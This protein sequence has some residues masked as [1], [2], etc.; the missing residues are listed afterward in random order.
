[1]SFIALFVFVLLSGQTSRLPDA[2][3]LLAQMDAAMDKFHSLQFDIESTDLRPSDANRLEHAN[4]VMISMSFMSPDKW[5]AEFRSE[6][7]NF[8]MVSDGKFIWT[9]DQ[10][11]KQYSKRLDDGGPNAVLSTFGVKVP[12]TRGG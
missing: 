6:Y 10:I 2:R 8:I 3:R 9:Y 12:E 7:M 11:K 4:D 5:R 1:M